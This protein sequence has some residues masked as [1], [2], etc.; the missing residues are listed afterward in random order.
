MRGFA[1]R[2]FQLMLLRR[3]ADFQPELVA[4]AYAKAG[5][6]RAD[7]LAAHNRWQS[8]LRS[9][10]AP[11]GLALYE[12]VLGPP[13]GERDEAVGDVTLTALTWPLAGLWPELRWELMVGF[14]GVVLNGWLVRAPGAPIPVLDRLEP[15]SC[16]VGDVVARYP[17]AQQAD[18]GTP[19]RWLIHLNGQRLIFVHGLLQAV[20]SEE[21]EES[22]DLDEPG[23]VTPAG[24]A[25]SRPA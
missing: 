21:P 17:A 20:R 4:R 11:A 13:D 14:G 22:D 23:E 6:T 9:P 25:H 19:S 3:M 10:K 7:Y 1:R 16:V 2:E 24:R 8:L 5:A 15:W 12:A 18:P